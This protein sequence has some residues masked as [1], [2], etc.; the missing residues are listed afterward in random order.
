MPTKNPYSFKAKVVK[1][2]KGKSAVAGAAY[3]AG[4]K[5]ID[6]RT[7]RRCNYSRK[8]GVVH[9]EILAPQNSPAWAMNR[10]ALW[11]RAEKAEN[12][13]DAQT[14]RKFILALPKS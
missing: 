3:Q 5:L 11:N 14:A 2:S 13:K 12:R 10:G 4:E 9:S 7:G 1:R 6:E 8:K